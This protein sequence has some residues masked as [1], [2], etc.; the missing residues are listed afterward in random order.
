MALPYVDVGGWSRWTIQLVRVTLAGPI[1]VDRAIKLREEKAWRARSA[2]LQAAGIRFNEEE[3]PKAGILN[4]RLS[5]VLQFLVGKADM[6]DGAE[7]PSYKANH[8]TT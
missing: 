3:R 7:Y 6:D 2:G 4:D 1:R 8:T 5:Y